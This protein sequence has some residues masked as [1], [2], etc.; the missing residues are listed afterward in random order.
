MTLLDDQIIENN[1]SFE[2]VAIP[3]T[4]NW[5]LVTERLEV[6]ILDATGKK[7]DYQGVQ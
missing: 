7:H 2:I 4:P 3:T 1:E 5:F 6:I